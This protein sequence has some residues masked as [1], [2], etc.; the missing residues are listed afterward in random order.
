MATGRI[1]LGEFQHVVQQYSPRR[2]NVRRYL[3]RGKISY[4]DCLIFSITGL[5][6]LRLSKAEKSYTTHLTYSREESPPAHLNLEIESLLEL[7]G[8]N[9]WRIY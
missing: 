6:K 9:L 5:E 4:T 8:I 2:Q 1:V 3:A 7:E